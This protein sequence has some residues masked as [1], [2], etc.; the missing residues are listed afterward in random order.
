MGSSQL[1]G[2][3]KWPRR[4]F[5]TKE[6]TLLGLQG[7]LLSHLGTQIISKICI[8][9]Y[10]LWGPSC[11]S[12]DG[13]KCQCAC[14]RSHLVTSGL[15]LKLSVF[16]ILGYAL[17]VCV[18]VGV[19]YFELGGGVYKC[20]LQS[21]EASDPIELELEAVSHLL[22]TLGTRLWSPAET[23]L[24]CPVPFFY[25]KV[26]PPFVFLTDKNR[27]AQPIVT[28][29]HIRNVFNRFLTI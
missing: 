5:R 13:T 23:H 9:R 25:K 29:L 7:Y 17:L 18:C 16:F 6:F 8:I 1:C 24:S 22:W 4:R 19:C 28:F 3:D 20:C 15:H 26:P 14:K 10:N 27:N 21:P 11:L 2:H 12:G